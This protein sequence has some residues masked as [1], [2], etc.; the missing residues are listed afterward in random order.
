MDG[1]QHEGVSN[2]PHLQARRQEIHYADNKKHD[3]S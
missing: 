3:S 1:I 2:Q